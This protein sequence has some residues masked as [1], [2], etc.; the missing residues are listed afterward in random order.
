MVDE[1]NMPLFGGMMSGQSMRCPTPF[2]FP[3]NP[4]GLA[5]FD[6][7]PSRILSILHHQTLL[8]EEALRYRGIILSPKDPMRYSNPLVEMLSKEQE[9]LNKRASLFKTNFRQS[10]SIQD[11]ISSPKEMTTEET[12]KKRS[13]H[14]QSTNKTDET[15]QKIDDDTDDCEPRSSKSPSNDS[16]Y[17][18]ASSFF[19]DGH[20]FNPLSST[21]TSSKEKSPTSSTSSTPPLIKPI[22][23]SALLQE[24]IE[25]E[26]KCVVCNAI[27]PSVWLLEQHAALQHANLGPEME[28]P[29]ICEQ[30]GQ[31]Y[32]YRSAYVKHREQNHRA[33]LPADKLFT[34]DVCG[35][36][37]RYLKSFKKHRLNHALERLHGKNGRNMLE[38]NSDLVTSSNE[39]NEEIAELQFAIKTEEDEE[40]QDDTVDSPTGVNFENTNDETGVKI[41][42]TDMEKPAAGLKDVRN[43]ILKQPSFLQ[44][45]EPES[46]MPSTSIN[47]LINAERIPNEQALGLNPQ[48]ASILNFLRVDAAEKQ[49]D[50]SRFACPFCGKCV[51]SKENLK[52]HVRKHTGERPFV[53]LFCG[54]AFGGKSDLTRHLRIHTGERPY[55]C[56]ACGKCFAR[57]DYL[58][59]HLT[60]HVHNSPR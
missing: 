54:R 3:F 36:Q 23:E 27:F 56:E 11:L 58:S 17:K 57:A 48:E 16:L 31:S 44:P 10:L 50:R 39:T 59:K 13:F 43:F 14:S 47:S 51:R 24:T 34:C 40:D 22:P 29:F 21:E 28:K 26:T 38:T 6:T 9:L 20:R 52:L 41:S 33:R 4:L 37:F 19:R 53:C 60:T 15:V 8:A 30:C 5:L 2:A 49:R 45:H 25:E 55:H 7:D 18:R 12:S 46:S 42:S 35:M 32:R 1:H